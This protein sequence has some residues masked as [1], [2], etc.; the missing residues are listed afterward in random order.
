MRTTK[1]VGYGFSYVELIGLI[2]RY[3]LSDDSPRKF[4]EGEGIF[5]ESESSVP[6]PSNGSDS[7]SLLDYGCLDD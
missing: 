1:D 6:L 3:E 4:L 2:S 7:K 5:D